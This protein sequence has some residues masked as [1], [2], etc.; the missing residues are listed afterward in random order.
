MWRII[1]WSGTTLGARHTPRSAERLVTRFDEQAEY[2]HRTQH[3]LLHSA[4]DI[5]HV[6]SI[7][8]TAK[9]RSQLER[10]QFHQPL[11]TS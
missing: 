11:E 1:I 4:P 6:D 3:T 8:E 10:L 9:N 7:L 2:Y 5:E